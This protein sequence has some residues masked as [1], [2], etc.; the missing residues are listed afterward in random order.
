MDSCSDEP[1][2][3]KKLLKQPIIR[4]LHGLGYEITRYRPPFPR[5]FRQTEV[6]L[7]CQVAPYT[8]TSPEAVYVL[9]EAVRYIA[10]TDVPGAIVEC[11]VWKGGSMMAIAKT[12]LDL[13]QADT[14][15]QHFDTSQG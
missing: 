11:G 4:V 9:P 8:M 6:D 5:D 13:V 15:P 14:D 12:L 1:Y 10:S 3:V 7:F 2:E